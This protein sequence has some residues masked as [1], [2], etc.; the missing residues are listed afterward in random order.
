M[1]D[2]VTKPKRALKVTP[3]DEDSK[4]SVVQNRLKNLVGELSQNQNGIRFRFQ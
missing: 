2:E 3:E 1:K 4:T